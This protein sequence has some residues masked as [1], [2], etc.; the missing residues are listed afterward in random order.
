MVSLEIEKGFEF[1]LNAMDCLRPGG[2]AVHTTEFNLSSND[3]TM[4]HETCV[5]FR[6]RDIEELI[7][8]LEK[9][10][11]FVFPFNSS[12]GTQNLDRHVDLPPYAGSPCLKIQ[13]DQYVAT[14]IGIMIRKN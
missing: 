4:E 10:G 3:Q 7:R 11:H 8:R 12:P 14:S 9:A 2:L 6:K 1:I 13:L 5:I